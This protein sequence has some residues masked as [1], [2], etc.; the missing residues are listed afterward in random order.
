[1]TYYLDIILNSTQI[2][3]YEMCTFIKL[4]LYLKT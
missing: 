4:Q 1:M 3:Q 2:N